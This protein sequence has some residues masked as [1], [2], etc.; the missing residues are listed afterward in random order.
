MTNPRNDQ[1]ESQQSLQAR[2]DKVVTY[3]IHE[4]GKQFAI[5]KAFPGIIAAIQRSQSID[6]VNQ[7]GQVMRRMNDDPA[8]YHKIEKGCQ[9]I[10]EHYAREGKAVPEFFTKAYD[11]YDYKE[12]VRMIS[13]FAENQKITPPIPAPFVPPLVSKPLRQVPGSQPV[14]KDEFLY[15]DKAAQVLKQLDQKVIGSSKTISRY[16]EVLNDKTSK[17]DSK[18]GHLF[19]LAKDAA[20][21]SGDLK[22]IFKRDRGELHRAMLV[23][24]DVT[25]GSDEKAKAL[26]KMKEIV[27]KLNLDVK[28]KIK[29]EDV[30]FGP[31]NNRPA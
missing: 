19:L 3:I 10:R 20:H 22:A 17:A 8:L 25:T 23:I 24:A 31:R 6:H 26:A 12:L 7:I 11:N 9:K 29:L 1:A 4:L 27:G 13:Q 5:D 21:R 15:L 14:K 18:A 30:N 16:I 2:K 28:G